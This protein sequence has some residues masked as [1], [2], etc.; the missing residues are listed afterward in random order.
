MALVSDV[1]AGTSPGANR[2]REG[3]FYGSSTIKSEENRRVPKMPAAQQ[4]V[5]ARAVIMPP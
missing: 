2:A 4:F 1:Y 5:K 3:Y